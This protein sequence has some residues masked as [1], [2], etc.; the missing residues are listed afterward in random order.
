MHNIPLSDHILALEKKLARPDIRRDD[1][2]MRRLL[3]DGFVE[4]GASGTRYDKAEILTL[5][6]GE[7]DFAAYV[8]EEFRLDTLSDT[9]ALATYMIPPRTDG[10]GNLKGGSRRGSVWQRIDERWQLV[11]HQGTRT[12]GT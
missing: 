6:A 9:V 7:T 12:T 5:L 11:F 3:A 4:I 2:Q 10:E 1:A 8:I